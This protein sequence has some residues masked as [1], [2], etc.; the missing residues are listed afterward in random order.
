MENSIDYSKISE[1][2]LSIFNDIFKDIFKV[3]IVY[4]LKFLNLNQA[5]STTT[6]SVNNIPTNT[7]TKSITREP[8][9][10]NNSIN[11]TTNIPLY[12]VDKFQ[13]NTNNTNNTNNTESRNNNTIIKTNEFLAYNYSDKTNYSIIDTQPDFVTPIN[14]FATTE[15]FEKENTEFNHNN[16]SYI[17]GSGVHLKRGWKDI[18]SINRPWFQECNSNMQCELVNGTLE[19]FNYEN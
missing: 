14:Y 3:I 1:S 15:D 12:R 17:N 2:I 16:N 4:L 7:T 8:R 6:N 13:S 5:N 10:P 11:N 18:N 9:I 19:K